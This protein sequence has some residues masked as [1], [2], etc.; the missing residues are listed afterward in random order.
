MKIL[1]IIEKRANCAL[2]GMIKDEMLVEASKSREVIV[3]IILTENELTRYHGENKEYVIAL[4]ENNRLKGMFDLGVVLPSTNVNL[5]L[6]VFTKDRVDCFT[7]G[8]FHGSVIKRRIKSDH[9]FDWNTIY[10]DE[11]YSYL[12]KIEEWIDSGNIVSDEYA[13][14]NTLN[15]DMFEDVFAPKRY[16][17][18]VYRVKSALEKERTIALSEVA[19]IIRPRPDSD[20]DKR[21]MHLTASE[22]RY[23]IDYSKLREGVLTNTPV[24]KNDILFMNFDQIYLVDEEPQQEIHISPNFY[25]IRPKSISPQYLLMYLQSETAKIIMQSLSMGNVL[26]R[27][28]MADMLNIPV[29]MPSLSEMEYIQ[30]FRLKYYKPKDIADYSR[31][32]R[33]MAYMLRLQG[34]EKSTE[35][36]DKPSDSVENIL[37]EEWS[38]N[39]RVCKTE[40]MQEF[41]ESDINELNTCFRG[42]A[43][44]ATLIL[45]GSILEAILIDWL[46]EIKGTN[47]F[48]EPYIIR[49]EQWDKRNNCVKR[50]RYGNIMYYNKEAG[51]ADYIDEIKE[52]ARPAWMKSREA[53]EIRKK[54]N[55]VHA[56]LCM[57]DSTEINEQTCREVIQYLKEVIETRGIR[58][59]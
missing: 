50:D 28:R 5:I 19:D 52:L 41:L 43:Y 25:I 42:K 54:R 22:W 6:Y 2:G 57:N 49:K 10:T 48:D 56:K 38:Q 59:K 1:D 17:E 24:Q 47:F 9:K 21:S 29:I 37:E 53:H 30:T 4:R 14:F 45:A 51:L 8:E 46:T 39:I 23:P 33:L 18:N 34:K 40:V 31:A 7:V 27:I 35:K 26:S 58:Q 36:N 55:L 13:K 44:K 20:R 3:P 32:N 11:F 12:H 15:N 16:S